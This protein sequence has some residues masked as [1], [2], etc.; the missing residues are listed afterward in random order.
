M[1]GGHTPG[2]DR[3][4]VEVDVMAGLI[5][6]IATGPKLSKDLSREEARAGL[7]GILDGTVHPV[8]A[9]IFLIALRMKRESD[10]ENLG[11]LDALLETAR[12][13]AVDVE[14]LVDVSEPY[15]GFTRTLPVSPFLPAVLAACGVPAVSHG[16][17]RMGPKH[18]VTHAQVL[19]AAGVPVDLEGPT[20]AAQVER[21]D[22]GWCYVDQSR[23][24]PALSGLAPLRELMVKRTALST[25]ERVMAP[26]RS[27]QATHLFAG[28]VH[29]AYPQVY[30]ALA[31][32][33]GFDVLTLVRG[34]EGGVLPSLRQAGQGWAGGRDGALAHFELT[35]GAVGVD[36][37]VRGVPLPDGGGDPAAMAARQG[38][39]ALGGESGV[40]RD[41]LIYACA[42]ALWRTGRSRGLAEGAALGRQVLDSGAALAHL[43]A[44]G[45]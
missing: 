11:M 7:L 26:L 27:T 24:A 9:A 21:P 35:P 10:D 4:A 40:A 42:V 13:T 44:A 3:A 23:F 20:A 6:R 25:L 16:V 12:A 41:A 19:R 31:R 28:Y 22:V 36:Q 14:L 15:D 1:N 37:T 5:Q 2:V 8:Q 17:E 30:A 32:R 34:V 18:G 45:S 43:R 33:A 29:V 38:L 39:A